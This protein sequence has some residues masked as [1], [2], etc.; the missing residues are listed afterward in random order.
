MTDIIRKQL[1]EI[2]GKSRN[3]PQNKKR[4]RENYWNRDVSHFYIL[5][6]RSAS[7]TLY[8]SVLMTSSQIPNTTSK[9]AEEDMMTFSYLNSMQI[10]QMIGY[11]MKRNF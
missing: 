8:Q 4:Y 11:S 1:D 10:G 9:S 3:I 6:I 2:M 5:N 7:I